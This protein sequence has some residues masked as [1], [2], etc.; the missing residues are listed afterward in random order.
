MDVSSLQI[1]ELPVL[2]RQ[3]QL[4]MMLSL[5]ARTGVG[6]AFV[7]ITYILIVLFLVAPEV[8]E[9]SGA[10]TASDIWYEPVLTHI[11]SLMLFP[12][13]RWL[14]RHRASRRQTAIPFP[15]SHAS[16]LQDCTG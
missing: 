16:T 8:I 14:C 9:Q 15:R 13:E 3:A 7:L 10:T 5:V 11:R 1:L 4:A 2:R 12:Q 6:H